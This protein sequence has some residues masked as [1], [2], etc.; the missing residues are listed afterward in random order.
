MRQAL[1][2][3]YLVVAAKGRTDGSFPL[4]GYAG[5]SGRL[6]VAARTYLSILED[7]YTVAV[8]LLGPPGPPKLLLAPSP[9]RGSKVGSERGF[10]LQASLAL[11]GEDSCFEAYELSNGVEGVRVLAS[12]GRIVY[13]SEEGSSSDESLQS[14]LSADVIA[15]GG[16]VDPPYDVHARLKASA[17]AVVSLAPLSFHTD[18]VAA[19]VSWLRLTFT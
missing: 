11:R 8:L 7:N 19:Y 17:S 3:I 10:M 15:M 18:H 2:P 1:K 5:P 12:A 9:C 14:L 4:R 13:L 16:H 6:D